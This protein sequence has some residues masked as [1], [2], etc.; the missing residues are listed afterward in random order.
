MP[1]AVRCAMAVHLSAQ[2]KSYTSA[3]QVVHIS[4]SGTYATDTVAPAI[5]LRR[6][7]QIADQQHVRSDDKLVALS[8]LTT[9][10]FILSEAS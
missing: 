3:A 5:T 2:L 4:S 7:H 10:G 9:E 1:L 6:P 8:Y